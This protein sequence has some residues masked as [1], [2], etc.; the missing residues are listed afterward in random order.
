MK[1]TIVVLTAA[2]LVALVW[3]FALSLNT[4]KISNVKTQE[5]KSLPSGFELIK[6]NG[7]KIEETELNEGMVLL[8]VWASWCITCLVEHRFLK[9]LSNTYNIDVIGINY[10]D[11]LGDAIKYLDKNGDPY[12]YSIHDYDGKYALKLGVTGAPETFLLIDGEIVKHRVGEVN[13]QVWDEEF[14]HFF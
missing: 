7:E 2:L 8:N 4:P 3:F 13:Q 14:S 11:K 9:E 1:K 6:L 12:I 5:G 10:K